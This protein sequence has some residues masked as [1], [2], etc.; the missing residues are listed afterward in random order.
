MDTSPDDES[1]GEGEVVEG[2]TETDE[3]VLTVV[4]NDCLDV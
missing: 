2:D 1:A 4:S 3:A